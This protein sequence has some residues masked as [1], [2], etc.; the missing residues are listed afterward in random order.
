MLYTAGGLKAKETSSGLMVRKYVQS[1]G[2]Q[3]ME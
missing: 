1:R 3:F 2:A